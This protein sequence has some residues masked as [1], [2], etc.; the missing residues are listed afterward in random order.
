VSAA[1][2]AAGFWRTY[3]PTTAAGVACPVRVGRLVQGGLWMAAAIWIAAA[4]LFL[5]E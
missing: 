3:E 1:F 2:V 4:T 5:V